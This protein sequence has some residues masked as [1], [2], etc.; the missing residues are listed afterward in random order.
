MSI[1]S[2]PKFDRELNKI[3]SFIAINSAEQAYYVS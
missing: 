3:L 2:K 1:V